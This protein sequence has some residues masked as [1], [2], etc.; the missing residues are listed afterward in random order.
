MIQ[1]NARARN[2]DPYRVA[3]F[4]RQETVFSPRAESHANAYGLMQLLLDTA[5]RTARRVGANVP[6]SKEEL[7]EPRLNI[8]LGTAYLREQLD[9]YDGR[10]ELAAAAYNAGP[11]RADRWKVE[12]PAELDEWT[13][14][15]PFR[16]TRQYVQ[17]IV[18]NTLQYQRLYDS[19]GQFRPE[20]GSRPLRPPTAATTTTAPAGNGDQVRPRRV[21][22]GDETSEDS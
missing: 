2:L 17:G 16:E 18:R 11:G 19:N 9:R 22:E 4:I 5:Q 6:R 13:E 21:P 12:L 3:A 20:V 14:A 15:V 7:F 8:R 10:I 1:E